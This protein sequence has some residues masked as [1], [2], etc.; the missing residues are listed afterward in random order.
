MKNAIQYKEHWLMKNSTAYELFQNWKEQK[1]PVLAKANR[2]K[3]ED[4]FKMALTDHDT[5]TK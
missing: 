5:T 3:F 2:K 4:H 1:D